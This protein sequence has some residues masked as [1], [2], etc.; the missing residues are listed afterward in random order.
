L[1]RRHK[2]FKIVRYLGQYYVTSYLLGKGRVQ[3]FRLKRPIDWSL[4]SDGPILRLY[5]ID[6]VLMKMSVEEFGGYVKFKD[7]QFE[8]YNRI[9]ASVFK[10]PNK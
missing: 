2:E 10:Y 8:I 7:A 3:I 6:E 9:G 1:F 5:A 4:N